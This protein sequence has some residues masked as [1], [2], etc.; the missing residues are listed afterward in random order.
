MGCM[1]FSG[2]DPLCS[3]VLFTGHAAGLLVG[4]YL[5]WGLS[6]SLRSVEVS[7]EE[8]GSDAVADGADE[9]NS[10]DVMHVDHAGPLQ[11]WAGYASFAMTLGLMVVGTVVAR[12]GELPPPKG[13]ELFIFH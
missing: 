2:V 6:P 8:D 9:D 7:K 4:M 5:G 13:L 3:C 11:R 1:H 12:T 10:V